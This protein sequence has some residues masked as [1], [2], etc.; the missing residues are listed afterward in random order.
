MN[1]CQAGA[2]EKEI[3]IKLKEVNY[4]EN[5]TWKMGGWIDSGFLFFYSISN[6]FWSFG[7]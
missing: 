1:A 7:T 4:A 3:I 6:T 2:A 5:K